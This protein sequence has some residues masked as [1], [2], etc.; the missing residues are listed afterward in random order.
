MLVLHVQV[1]VMGTSMTDL[2]EAF[3]NPWLPNFQRPGSS[4]VLEGALLRLIQQPSLGEP[5]QE[6]TV[7]QRPAGPPHAGTCPL[8]EVVCT[9]QSPCKCSGRKGC[10]ALCIL[11]TRW[12]YCRSSD[13]K[14][15]ICARKP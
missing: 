13:E 9:K 6:T 10:G 3:H 14:P 1:Y 2:M 5:V 4:E 7:P 11:C 12:V 8:P 15:P